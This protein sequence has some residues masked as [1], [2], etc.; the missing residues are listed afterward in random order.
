M[1][2]SYTTGNV[3]TAVRPGTSTTYSSGTY[4][5]VAGRVTTTATN[6]VPTTYGT[7]ITTPASYNP[8]TTTLYAGNAGVGVSGSRVVNTGVVG[9]YGV[10]TGTPTR[11][12]GVSYG[13]VNVVGG[14]A[15][16]GVGATQ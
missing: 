8:P 6:I 11:V 15:G 13:G 2:D 12:G 3:A 5:P 4:S 16:V 10:R 7:T 9:A 14:G 1:R